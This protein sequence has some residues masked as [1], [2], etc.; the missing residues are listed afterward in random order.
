MPRGTRGFTAR[1]IHK[2]LALRASITSELHFDSVRL[3]SSA[4]LPGV[5]GLRGPLSC[6]TEAR[7]GIGWGVTGAARACLESALS[8]CDHADAVREADRRVP[9]HAVQAGLDGRLAVPGAASRAPSRAAQGRRV[10]E[11]GSGQRREDRQ[12][13]DRH[14]HRQAGAHDPRRPT[15]SRSS[16]R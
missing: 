2:K 1:D 7:F 6:L 8:Y 16:T 4:V 12:R 14:R 10:P 15:G 3:P 11:A 13:P 9:A 5:T